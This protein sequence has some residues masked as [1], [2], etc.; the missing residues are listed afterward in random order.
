MYTPKPDIGRVPVLDM[1]PDGQF[2]EPATTPFA[3]RLLRTAVVVAAVGTA[4]AI[5]ALALWFALLLI[6]VVLVAALVAYGAFRWRLWRSGGTF[7]MG[8]VR[9]G[10]WPPAGSK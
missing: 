7:T 4:V 5:A 6:P 1:T 10:R 9:W 3:D 2:R 8:P